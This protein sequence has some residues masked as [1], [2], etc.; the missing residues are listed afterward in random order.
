MPATFRPDNDIGVA[1]DRHGFGIAFDIGD[2]FDIVEPGKD[3]SFPAFQDP[4]AKTLPEIDQPCLGMGIDAAI[5]LFLAEFEGG[6]NQLER[7][8]RFAELLAD[9]KPFQLREISEEA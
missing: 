3:K 5:P 8:T 1:A 4:K 9:G 7:G 6:A 2:H